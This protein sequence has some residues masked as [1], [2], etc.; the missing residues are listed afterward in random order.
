MY[1]LPTSHMKIF[2]GGRFQR[3]KPAQAPAIA[4]AGN[5]NPGELPRK[6]RFTMGACNGGKQFRFKCS[7]HTKNNRE[8]RHDQYDGCATSQE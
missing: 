1:P 8:G 3:R 2:A 6:L 4:A 5:I 7:K